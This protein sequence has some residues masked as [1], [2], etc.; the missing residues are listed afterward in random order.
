VSLAELLP[1][2]RALPRAEQVELLHLLIDGVAQAPPVSGD[3]GITDE[4]RKWFPPGSVASV[5]FPEPN[6]EGVAAAMKGL[7][8][9]EGRRE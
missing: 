1:A 5:W 3:D 7:K 2:I 8:E 4:M 9:F 6:P